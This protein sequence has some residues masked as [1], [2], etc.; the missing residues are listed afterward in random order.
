MAFLTTST[1]SSKSALTLTGSAT[2]KESLTTGVA[3]CGAIQFETKLAKPR[4]C[5][6]ESWGQGATTALHITP[7]SL[8]AL[9]NRAL[10]RSAATRSEEHTSELQVTNAHLVCRLL[11]V[12]KK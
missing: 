1:A 2:F 12:K 5:D 11:L 8:V 9:L 6:A 7:L 10:C 4:A 3:G